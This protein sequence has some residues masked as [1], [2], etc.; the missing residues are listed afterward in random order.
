MAA[1]QGKTSNLNGLTI[2][3]AERGLPIPAVG[4]TRFRPPYNPGA[5]S[6]RSSAATRGGAPAAAAPHAAAR[7][8]HRAPAA[9]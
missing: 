5:A 7:L 1:D 2:L 6:A 8:A 9:R 4:T 3:A